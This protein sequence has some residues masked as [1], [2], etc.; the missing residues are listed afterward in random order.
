MLKF[1]NLEIH[2]NYNLAVKFDFPYESKL[3]ITIKS[4]L[5]SKHPLQG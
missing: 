2:Y 3:R 5:Q 1:L 4:C